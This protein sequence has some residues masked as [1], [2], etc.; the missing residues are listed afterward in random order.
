MTNAGLDISEWARDGVNIVPLQGH[1]VVGGKVMPIGVAPV[2]GAARLT[3]RG[4]PLIAR[5]RLFGVY[6]GSAWRA[7]GRAGGAGPV[8]EVS[9]QALD[10]FLG[11]LAGGAYID[12]LAEYNVQGLAIQRGTFLGSAVVGPDPAARVSD[13]DIRAMLTQRLA[14]GE[15]PPWDANTL[16]VVYLPQ[17]TSVEQGGALSC[18]V[19]CGYHDAIVDQG[20]NPSA[21]YAVLP[22]PGC[23]GCAQGTDGMQLSPFDALTATTSHEVA[24]AVTDP[25]PGTGWYDDQNGEIGD[26]CAWQLAM[27]DGYVVQKEWSN[28][29]G[30][31][32]GP[33]GG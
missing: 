1:R 30:D 12:M 13:D 5:A 22:Y 18:R 4:G 23:A 27:L 28:A 21:Y 25:V 31:C 8:R 19:F 24:E 15:L 3:Y 10:A 33:A 26:I 6:W 16:Y 9:R 14:D 20:G 11:D 29:A 32:V 7:L 17:G 2:A